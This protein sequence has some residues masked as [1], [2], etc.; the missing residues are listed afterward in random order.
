MLI[1]MMFWELFRFQSIAELKHWLGIM[2]GVV[3]YENYAYTAWHFFDAR[4][5]FLMI[6]AILGAT[7]FSLDRIQK[8][9]MRFCGTKVGFA[10]REVGVLFLFIL[11]ILF[12]VNS[13]YSPFI[14]FQY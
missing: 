14:Y 10:I 7:V 12:M 2:L 3:R 1:V 9:S 11:A 4:M 6:L 5:I 8:F 13:T